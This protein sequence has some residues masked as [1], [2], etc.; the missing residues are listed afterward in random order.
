MEEQNEILLKIKKRMVYPMRYFVICM[1]IFLVMFFVDKMID[2]AS[3][4]QVLAVVSQ[5]IILLRFVVMAYFLGMFV[6]G[7]KD[8]TEE[9]I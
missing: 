8:S 7:K 3:F 5:P 9:G 6:P 1:A 4:G 2:G